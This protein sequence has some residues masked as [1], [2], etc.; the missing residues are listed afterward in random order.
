[1]RSFHRT[2]CGLLVGSVV[3]LLSNSSLRADTITIDP[4]GA[5]AASAVTDATGFDFAL[6]NSLA[7]GG[8]AAIAKFVATAAVTTVVPGLGTILTGGTQDSFDLF[9]QSKIDAIQTTTGTS[10]LAPGT[11]MTAVL[12]FQEVIKSVTFN[13]DGSVRATFGLASAQTNNFLEL[14]FDAT[15]DADNLAGTGFNDGTLILSGRISSEGPSDFTRDTL[16]GGPFVA[17]DQNGVNNYDGAGGNTGPTAASNLGG[18]ISSVRGNG[19]T[20]VTAEVLAYDPSFF[21]L[22]PGVT[23]AFSIAE[24]TLSVP[25][26]NVDP[27]GRFAE[28]PGGV[29]PVDAG[30]GLGDVVAGL[31]SVNGGNIV[32]E[33]GGVSIQLKT[34]GNSSFVVTPEPGSLAMFTLGLAG[35]ALRGLKR[36]K[37]AAA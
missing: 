8:N 13:E 16:A 25:F 30:A 36:R 26:N 34:D 6:G 1:M 7:Q 9:Y 12:A 2:I 27:S 17:L 20:N 19:Q 35:L 5:G 11:E 14:W 21:V 31:G 23:I 24:T 29:A 15:P 22:P 28:A 37:L 10:P 18:A 33:G 4:D 3:T 32:T